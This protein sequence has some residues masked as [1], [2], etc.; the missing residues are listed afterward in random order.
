MKNFLLPLV[1]TLPLVGC[2][3]FGDLSEAVEAIQEETSIQLE[4]TD[5]AYTSGAITAA[6]RDL[7]IAEILKTSK[8]RLD[9][10]AADAGNS[11]LGTGSEI[12]D[13]LLL[14]LF[15][16]GSTMGALSLGRKLRGPKVD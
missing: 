15:G 7:M 2:A 14:V 12:L 6:E 4:E 10:A 1:L 13:L 16:S 11:L 3:A 9:A 5:E 8:A